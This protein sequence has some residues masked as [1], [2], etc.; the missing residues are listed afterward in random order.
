MTRSGRPVA[1]LG[2][3]GPAKVVV[4]ALRAARVTVAALYDDD[5]A[6]W[7][8]EA[9]GVTIRGPILAAAEDGHR[10]AVLAIGDNRAR[11]RL[12]HEPALAGME[13]RTVVHPAAWLDP[14]V[15]LG[16]GT[17]VF[18]GAVIQPDS[19]L[20]EHVI[21]NTGASID[22]DCRVGD[23]VHVAPGARLAGGVTADEGA[24]F[25]IGSVAIPGMTVGAWA[26]LGAGSAAV[27]PVPAGAV[28]LGVP[29]RV[30]KHGDG[31]S[32]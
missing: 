2:S 7:G 12:A 19:T 4:S 9:A 16:A 27:R 26:T 32:R 15:R 14:S 11:H 13:W 21:V 1:V 18:A 23:F 22:H 20:G 17:V 30:V 29:A 25:G 8:S 6:R 5:E 31:E 24:F 3:G 28:A 10:E